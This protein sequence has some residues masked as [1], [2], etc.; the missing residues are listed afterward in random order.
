MLSGLQQ[1]VYPHW[2]RTAPAHAYPCH[3]ANGVPAK[4]HMEQAVRAEESIHL[5]SAYSTHTWI[6]LSTHS[7]LTSSTRVYN[8]GRF[9]LQHYKT[10]YMK[11]KRKRVHWVAV[12]TVIGENNRRKKAK[13]NKGD[14]SGGD[15]PVRR[16]P[17]TT[18][19]RQR[20]A[21]QQRARGKRGARALHTHADTHTRCARGGVSVRAREERSRM[22]CEL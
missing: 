3:A 20:R 8:T 1:L 2:H 15:G 4:N 10:K 18:R 22:N 11:R 9:I 21:R 14:N 5:S 7:C 6:E 12:V 19:Q 16:A 17:H 13:D